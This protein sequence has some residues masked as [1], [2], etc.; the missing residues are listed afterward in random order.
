M[1]QGIHDRF[2]VNTE[3]KVVET[4]AV[5]G[6]MQA[7]FEIPSRSVEQIGICREE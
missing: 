7:H 2:P 1:P 5:T 6:F 3:R 4:K